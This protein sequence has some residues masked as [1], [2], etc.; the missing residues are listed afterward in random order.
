MIQ[1]CI[2]IDDEPAAIEALQGFIGKTPDLEL[3]GSFQDPLVALKQIA[4]GLLP[5]IT[6][7]D[8]DMPHIS[9][10]E[11][12]DLLA[13]KTSI[14]FTTAH[15]EYAVQGFDKRVTD[16]LLKPISFPRFMKALAKITEEDVRKQVPVNISNSDTFFINPGSKGKL[17]GLKYSEIYYIEGS[18]NFINIFTRD[19]RY[20]PYLS[21]KEIE[22]ALPPQF[23]RV[24]KS[25]IINVD[26]ISSIAESIITLTNDARI[27]LGASYKDT[28]LES[29]EPRILRSSR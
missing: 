5:D 20:T 3:L 7:L 9:G 8:I 15:S 24:H 2:I 4:N 6:F 23:S 21:M 19:Q 26:M 22:S 11:V 28:F 25:Y 18:K 10:L 13:G 12:A 27:H 17:I 29:L 1:T 16:F 14:I